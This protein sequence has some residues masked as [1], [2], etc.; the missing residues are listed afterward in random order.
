M[1]RSTQATHHVWND[2]AH[3]PDRPGH[4]HRRRR[5]NPGPHKRQDLR[6]PYI[7]PVPHRHV[8]AQRH[9]IVRPRA[10]HQDPQPRDQEHDQ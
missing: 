7:H 10:A 9:M 3:E 2:H 6:P 8:L 1:I 4:G 5:D